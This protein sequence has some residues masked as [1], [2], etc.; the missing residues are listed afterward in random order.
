MGYLWSR[1]SHLM[2]NVAEVEIITKRM[3][4]IVFL[5]PRI[6]NKEA[7]TIQYSFNV[8]YPVVVAIFSEAQDPDAKLIPASKENF[9]KANLY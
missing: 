9:G 3:G 4:D 1:G 6:K 7:L 8:Y 5:F 2:G